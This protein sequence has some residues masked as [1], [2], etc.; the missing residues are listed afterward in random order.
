MQKFLNSI[1]SQVQLKCRVILIIAGAF[2]VGGF[3]STASAD[4]L[5]SPSEEV[6]LTIV[7]D[8]PYNNDPTGVAFDMPMLLK[9]GSQVITTKTPWSDASYRF[10]GV[11]FKSIMKAAGMIEG[12]SY[13]LKALN[14]YEVLI[15]WEDID[16]F[17]PLIAYSQ[18]NV[19]L[20]RRDRGPLWL[21]FPRDDIEELKN[22]RF[23]NYWIWQLIEIRSE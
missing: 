10:K 9:V 16:A 23:D 18:N 2:W 6:L 21:I 5:P 20:S 8:G 15:S 17:N 11:P 3:G 7:G 1:L 14:D 13:R 22:G 4:A 19:P 12:R